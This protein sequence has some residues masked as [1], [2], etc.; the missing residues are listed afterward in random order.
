MLHQ[1]LSD[2][3]L[4]PRKKKFEFEFFQN[5]KN[6]HTN[7]SPITPAPIKTIFLGTC[8]SESAPVDETIVSS[9]I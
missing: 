7:S 6:K 5:K 8:L 9:S 4:N 2:S 1:H 3:I